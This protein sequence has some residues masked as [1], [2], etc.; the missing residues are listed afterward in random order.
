M[1]PSRGRIVD[2]GD[3]MRTITLHVGLPQRER[4]C[5]L[6][7]EL[8]H[9]ELDLLWPEGTPAGVIEHGERLV[10]RISDDRLLPV[11]DLQE[12]VDRRGGVIHRWEIADEFGVSEDV[13]ERQS[14]RVAWGF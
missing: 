12:W 8:I 5:V 3:G 7:H 1:H 6:S 4:S 2:R 14:R 13:A 9:D 11:V 10:Q